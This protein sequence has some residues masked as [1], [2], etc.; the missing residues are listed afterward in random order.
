MSTKYKASST[1]LPWMNQ[2][3]CYFEDNMIHVLV[4]QYQMSKNQGDLTFNVQYIK[5][6]KKFVDNIKNDN[7]EFEL[8]DSAAE[9]MINLAIVMSLEIVESSRLESKIKTLPLES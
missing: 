2:P 9:E 1:N 3:V 7:V 5:Y 4:D 8:N 6:P